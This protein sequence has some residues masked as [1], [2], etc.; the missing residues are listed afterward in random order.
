MIEQE[1]VVK[2]KENRKKVEELTRTLAIDLIDDTSYEEPSLIRLK[3]SVRHYVGSVTNLLKRTQS[4]ELSDSVTSAVIL[5]NKGSIQAALLMLNRLARQKDVN[6]Q[7][8]LAEFHCIGINGNSVHGQNPD[9]GLKVLDM[10]TRNNI[11]EAFYTLGIY[12]KHMPDILSATTNFEQ[13]Y[14]LGFIR[15][16]AEL[17][18][19]YK[20]QSRN[21]ATPEDRLLATQKLNNIRS[22]LTYE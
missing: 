14:N 15:A 3:N 12:H 5:L 7:L 22:E 21:G 17:L 2:L 4:S 19:V 13:S 9:Y 6:A 20:R 11:P 18:S 1:L 10:L 16:Y 8:K